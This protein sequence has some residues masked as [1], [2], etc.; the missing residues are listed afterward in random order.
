METHA[1]LLRREA[2]AAAGF[3]VEFDVGTEAM[4]FTADNGD[5]QR[6]SQRTGARK[7]SGRAPDTQPDGQRILQG[8]R[9]DTLPGERSTVLAR[10]VDLR[11]LTNL[12]QQFELLGKERVVV[13]EIETEEG[14]GLDKRAAAGNNLRPALRYQIK[15]CEL[16]KNTHRIGCAQHRDR[17]GKPN[18]FW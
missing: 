14:K 15:G 10:P 5:H 18:T 4:R 9:V 17:A 16:L 1:Q 13:V 12:Q 8:P 7:G 11:A 2:R 6:K 3:A